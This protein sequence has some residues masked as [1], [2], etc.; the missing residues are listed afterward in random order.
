MAIIL[1]S[2]TCSYHCHHDQGPVLVSS[3]LLLPPIIQAKVILVQAVTGKPDMDRID[4]NTNGQDYGEFNF[5]DFIQSIHNPMISH[6]ITFKIGPYNSPT[7]AR[8]GEEEK[9]G[10]FNNNVQKPNIKL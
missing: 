5:V 4:G 9:N 8:P 10:C 7:T 1:L 3:L 2:I 6:E